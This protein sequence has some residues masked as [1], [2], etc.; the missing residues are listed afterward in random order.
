MHY[1]EISTD[2]H[3]AMYFI[4]FSNFE[5]INKFWLTSITLQLIYRFLNQH[6]YA[7][8]FSV[9]YP[10]GYRSSYSTVIGICLLTVL[11][12]V[13]FWVCLSVFIKM[14][15]NLL[16]NNSEVVLYYILFCKNVDYFT[17]LD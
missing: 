5:I 11:F 8:T 9:T 3:E 17:K 2:M 15:I 10:T 13:Q 7:Y 16:V 4:S 6:V 12:S 1:L 14:E